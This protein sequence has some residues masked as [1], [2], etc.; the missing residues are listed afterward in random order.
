VIDLG[1]MQRGRGLIGS[2]RTGTAMAAQSEKAK[3]YE[4]LAQAMTTWDEIRTLWAA[5]ESND[6]PDWDPGKALEYLVVRAFE[7]S[8]L[9]AEYPYDVPPGGKPI[10]Q[11]DGLV[12]LGH[13]V[14]LIEC[15]DKDS[16]DVEVVA[17]V[18]HQ[19]MRRPPTT[20]ASVFVAGTFTAPALVLA[21]LSVPHRV[22]LWTA[23]DIATAVENE[24]FKAPLVEKYQHL[25]RFGLL[26]HS[27][28]YKSLEVL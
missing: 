26:D 17:K 11:I 15:K 21:D 9:T 18:R 12:Y 6:T 8:G 5:I 28:H 7:L 14:F 22:L 20:L 13:L 24:D 19:L 10:E 2:R 23:E 25:C 27:P 3:K 4:M 16:N 1:V